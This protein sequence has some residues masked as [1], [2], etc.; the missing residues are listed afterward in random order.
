[1]VSDVETWS[2][3]CCA[4]GPGEHQKTMAISAVIAYG[5][6][7]CPHENITRV[8]NRLV[9]NP[10]WAPCDGLKPKVPKTST[11]SYSKL[12]ALKRLAE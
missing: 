7:P 4:G 10:Q 6:I 9:K 5:V 1:M 11:R 12:Q 8:E 2:N 3:Q